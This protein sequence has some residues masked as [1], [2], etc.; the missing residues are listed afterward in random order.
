MATIQDNSIRLPL[1]C[2]TPS[3]LYQRI[4]TTFFSFICLNQATLPIVLLKARDVTLDALPCL[5]KSKTK[6]SSPFNP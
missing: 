1:L 5:S 6:S 4:P 3:V 2:I